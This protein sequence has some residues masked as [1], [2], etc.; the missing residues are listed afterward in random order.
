MDNL[1]RF[2]DGEEVD[3]RQAVDP[4]SSGHVME[5]IHENYLSWALYAPRL[6]SPTSPVES[7]TAIVL[8]EYGISRPTDHRMHAT[9][10]DRY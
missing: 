9:H 8:S 4:T 7:G 1:R 10:T 6:P 5:S 3:L 2:L